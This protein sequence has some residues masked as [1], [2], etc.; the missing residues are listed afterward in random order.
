LDNPNCKLIAVTLP[1]HS[2]HHSNP[3]SCLVQLVPAAFSTVF[4]KPFIF[5]RPFFAPPSLRGLWTSLL[6][7]S[8][9]YHTICPPPSPVALYCFPARFLRVIPLNH[10][11]R[12][13]VFS[14]PL[15]VR[16]NQMAA[17]F[18]A[19]VSRRVT[20]FTPFCFVAL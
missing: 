10:N 8:S 4:F 15:S 6:V 19:P 5:W 20:P 16:G 7:V 13:T 2:P 12:G 11:N 1:A 9:F 18:S 3:K 17:D 14:V